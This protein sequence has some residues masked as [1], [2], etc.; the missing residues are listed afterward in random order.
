MFPCFWIFSNSP[1]GETQKN[2]VIE[3]NGDLD[4]E[5]DETF[6]LNLTAVT[7]AYLLDPQG[8]G[9]IVN[10]DAAPAGMVQFDSA[11]YSVNETGTTATITVTRSSGSS[12]RDLRKLLNSERQRDRR[13]GLFRNFGYAYMGQRRYLRKIVHDS[14]N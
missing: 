9:T 5:P 13:T 2:V 3:I 6:F 14:D 12:R 8:I 1:P 11:T 10:D 4:I 7:N